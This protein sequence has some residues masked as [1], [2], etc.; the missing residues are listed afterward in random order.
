MIRIKWQRRVTWIEWIRG[1]GYSQVHILRG[2]KT[3]CG[4]RWP[5]GATVT[6]WPFAPIDD[7]VANVMVWRSE[8]CRSCVHML[9]EAELRWST[10]AWF[11][12]QE[13]AANDYD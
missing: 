1:G 3:R 12:A 4:R 10:Y 2:D 5:T 6:R 13:A 7:F 8:A 9:T 11:R